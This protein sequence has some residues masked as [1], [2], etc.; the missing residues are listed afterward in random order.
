[1]VRQLTLSPS[2]PVD[3]DG[4][5]CAAMSMTATGTETAAAHQD[6]V[7]ERAEDLLD[8]YGNR[9]LRL[10]YAYLRHMEDAE[11]VLQDTLLQYLRSRPVFTD[12]EHEK[13]WLLRVAINISKNKLKY[14]RR[15]GAEELDEN[16]PGEQ[17]EDLAF[18]WE[19]VGTL[20]VAYREVVHLFYQEGFTTAEIGKLL[21]RREAT[22]RSQLHRAREMLREKL[23]EVYDFEV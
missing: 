13:A 19:A 16:L 4:L 23:K 15:W 6:Q 18:V 21:G 10:A 1:M 17:R 5:L 7:T 9:I 12:Q 14:G 11:D 2:L 3:L 22:V 20:P 8:R